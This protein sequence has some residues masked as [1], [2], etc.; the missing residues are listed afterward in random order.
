LQTIGFGVLR[1][2]NID[3]SATR[4]FSPCNRYTYNAADA[5][6]AHI[7]TSDPRACANLSADDAD[8]LP[9]GAAGAMA[10]LI[11]LADHTA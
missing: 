2:A 7:D 5:A 11:T 3:V 6:T 1:F 8:G 4:A 10:L 9:G